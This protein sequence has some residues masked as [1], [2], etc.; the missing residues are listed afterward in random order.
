MKKFYFLMAAM[1]T[2][3]FANAQSVTLD[4][5]SPANPETITYGSDNVWNQTYNETDYTF[6]EFSPFAFSHL[7]SGSSWGGSY[8]DGFTISRNSGKSGWQGNTAGGGMKLEDTGGAVVDAN[9]PY[10]IGYWSEFMETPDNHS[11]MMM[12]NDGQ[13]Y[14]AEGVWVT[15]VAN[16]YASVSGEDAY[17]RK[18]DQEGDSFTLVAHGVG[19]DDSEKTV[20]IEL[21]G[22][23]NGQFSA[24]SDWTYFDLSN[25]GRVESIY[26]TMTSTDSGTW[27]INT[28][29][30]FALSHLTIANPLPTAI[31]N[32]NDNVPA[33]VVAT[34]Y[35][36]IAGHESNRPHSGLNIVV[37]TLS[38]GS[39]QAIKRV[40]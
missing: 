5:N 17:A 8:W 7:I 19:P 4:L 31:D 36:D 29:T 33:E 9:E 39:R 18:F 21:A 10:L 3:A 15:N 6:I 2:F 20:S 37:N 26:F 13:N 12:F 24:V 34:K 28:P 16:A 32:I 38:D 25:L 27:G 14:R 1:A 40:F 30:Y 22:Y 23:H 11:T 35:Y